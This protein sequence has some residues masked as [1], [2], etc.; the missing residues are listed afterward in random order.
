[1]RRFSQEDADYEREFEH[2]LM[3]IEQQKKREVRDLL[4]KESDFIRNVSLIAI[5]VLLG[6]ITIAVNSF[7]R[8]Q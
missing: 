5:F 6:I 4:K 3:M 8:M 7:L 2:K 1:M